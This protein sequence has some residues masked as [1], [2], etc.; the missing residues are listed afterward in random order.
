MH[1]QQRGPTSASIAL[2][3]GTNIASAST[4]AN[5]CKMHILQQVSSCCISCN[6]NQILLH[7]DQLLHHDSTATRTNHYSTYQR[8]L[9]A[10]IAS[11]AAMTNHCKTAFENTHCINCK[12]D[13]LLHHLQYRD[14]PLHQ[15]QYGPTIATTAILQQGPMKTT[16]YHGKQ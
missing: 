7:Q 15:R 10:T 5:R 4:R 14:H 1:Q 9:G 3:P 11:T 6:R 13:K 12:S 8:Q 2:C 16:S